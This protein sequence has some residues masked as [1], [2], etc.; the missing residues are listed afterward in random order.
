MNKAV[1]LIMMMTVTYLGREKIQS[2][3]SVI[4]VSMAGSVQM[5]MIEK[6]KTLMGQPL[7]IIA[8]IN[9]MKRGSLS[10]WPHKLL[11]YWVI[12]IENGIGSTDSKLNSK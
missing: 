6:L 1:L 11:I 8:L 12:M 9:K 4:T 5:M 7:I 2:A 10:F 3:H